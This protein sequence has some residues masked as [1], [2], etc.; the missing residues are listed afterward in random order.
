MN[1]S[2]V[3]DASGKF[4]IPGGIDPHCHLELNFMNNIAVDD[5]NIGT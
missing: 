4:I 1:F 2:K 5:F 3:Y